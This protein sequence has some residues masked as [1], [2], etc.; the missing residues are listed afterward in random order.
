M[1]SQHSHVIMYFFHGQHA[2]LQ[3]THTSAAIFI[4]TT[5]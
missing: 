4:G 5:A 2:Q 3:V 1:L